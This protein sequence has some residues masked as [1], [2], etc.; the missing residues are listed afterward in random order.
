[1]SELIDFA[2]KKLKLRR[3]NLPAYVENVA[4]NALAKK[5]GFKLEGTLRKYHKIKSTGRIHDANIYG[6]L[7]EEWGSQK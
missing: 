7:R 6:L 1:M 2:F 4:S 3:L 5:L